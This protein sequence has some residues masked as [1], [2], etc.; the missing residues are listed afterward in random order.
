MPIS[1]FGKRPSGSDR[2]SERRISPADHNSFRFPVS[3]FRNRQRHW[4]SAEAT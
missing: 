2:I 1:D 4:R 3:G